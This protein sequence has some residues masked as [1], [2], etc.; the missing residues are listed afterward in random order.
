MAENNDKFKVQSVFQ[1]IRLSTDM[2]FLGPKDIL[3]LVKNSGT[4]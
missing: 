1:G 2:T 3:V 4:V